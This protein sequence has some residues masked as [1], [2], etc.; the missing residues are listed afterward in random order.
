[1]N[2]FFSSLIAKLLQNLICTQQLFH[3]FS[4]PHLHPSSTNEELK[5]NIGLNSKIFSFRIEC[6]T[7]KDHVEKVCV[8]KLREQHWSTIVHKLHSV[9]RYHR[10][11]MIHPQE[12]QIIDCPKHF[13]WTS[14]NFS[15]S[16]CQFT[17][18]PT[19]STDFHV[20]SDLQVSHVD[21][22]QLIYRYRNISWEIFSSSKK[23][24]WW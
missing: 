10:K 3:F 21:F 20:A 11:S 23:I 18:K 2:V 12:T 17:M 1:M 6:A 8:V 4:P 15:Q 16:S 24:I 13:N 5:K 7:R 9:S 14:D 22:H 19:P